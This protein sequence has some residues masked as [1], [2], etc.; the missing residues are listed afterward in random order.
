MANGIIQLT[1]KIVKDAAEAS[2][3]SFNNS[4]KGFQDRLNTVRIAG[5]GLQETFRILRAGI[6]NLLQL[7]AVQERAERK[8]EQAIRST[9]Q[10]AGF[11]ADELKKVA[12]SLQEVTVFGD[13]NILN[14]VTAQLLTFTN[15][16][17]DNFLRTQEAA[18]NLA[19]VL[20]GDLKSASIQ[21][22]KALN[23]P[24]ANLSALSRSGIQF[25]NE[26]EAVIKSLAETNRLAEAQTIILDELDKQYGGQAR[27]V[28]DLASGGMQQFFNV[29]GDVREELG[30]ILSEALLPFFK[31]LK[32]GLGIFQELP[33]FVK[34]VTAAVVILTTA[35]FAL[36]LSLGPVT[37]TLTALAAVG[38]GVSA[39]LS[40]ATRETNRLAEEVRKNS[41]VLKSYQEGLKGVGDEAAA[42]AAN[43]N[44]I[45]LAELDNSINA[46]QES[47]GQQLNLIE[48]T[49]NA[50]FNRL[51]K[52]L[53]AFQSAVRDSESSIKTITAEILPSP[54]S[55]GLFTPRTQELVQEQANLKFILERN[56]ANA[57]SVQRLIELG[58]QLKEN[59]GDSQKLN[60]IFKEIDKTI[61]II[62]Q[63]PF[64]S[65][66]EGVAALA[67][68]VGGLQ[69]LYSDLGD[70]QNRVAEKNKLIRVEEL[71][72]ELAT[73]EAQRIRLQLVSDEER[74]LEREF[75]IQKQSLEVKKQIAIET[76]KTED[77][78][79]LEQE[80]VLLRQQFQAETEV[81][82]VQR[83]RRIETVQRETT[84]E[85]DIQRL[86]IER[87]RA[88]LIENEVERL[89][90]EFRIQEQILERRLELARVTERTEEIIRLQSE[91]DITRERL[92]VEEE[93]A[94]VQQQRVNN[95]EIINLLESTT[96]RTRSIE[97][98][99]QSVLLQIEESRVLASAQ[100][101]E[102]RLNIRQEFAIRRLDIERSEL[103]AELDIQ[104]QRVESELAANQQIL[105]SRL[106]LARA[107]GDADQ[108]AA[109][110]AER[111]AQIEREAQIKQEF[112]D[113]QIAIDENYQ[114][115]RRA[116]ED[117]TN[118]QIIESR[119]RLEEQLIQGQDI[120][121]ASIEAG[122]DNLWATITST[123]QTG[124]EKVQAAFMAIV[125]TAIRGLGEWL[126]QDIIMSAR[127]V[128]VHQA[129]ESTKTAVTIQGVAARLGV[130]I[131]GI[132][133]EV[134]EVIKSIGIFLAQAAAKLVAFFASLGPIGLVAGLASIP[135]LIAGARAI[136]KNVGRFE[137]GA[138]LTQP[139]MG[140]FA[141]GGSPEAAIPLNERGAEFIAR[142]LPKIIVATPQAAS[143]DIPAL[144]EAL[145][146]RIE[147]IRIELR[148]EMD[149][150]Q[151]YRNTFPKYEKIEKGRRG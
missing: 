116:A 78:Q 39:Q 148:A 137:T 80:L 24:I 97:Q 96:Q 33:P 59:A 135:A 98:E 139:T 141:E 100:T 9:G 138:I 83:Q 52:Q 91:L 93:I 4:M 60:A 21:L 99:T 123:S 109:I 146:R 3:R 50:V 17:T 31:A 47:I 105:E 44:D 131:A 87:Q 46:T 140:L 103:V 45:S 122:Y 12:S 2:V 150:I 16:A 118:A 25:S 48:Q 143:N 37:L 42:L 126:K 10:A 86:S 41:T 40:A 127:S 129:G 7:S 27:A 113:R 13:E 73:L 28:A 79:K 85:Q 57:E 144:V 8:V 6:G 69:K 125:D 29:L 112:A 14:N 72:S 92:Q 110:E 151:F 95:Q 76:S 51:E 94:L 89:R 68:E 84:A 88:G 26:Q 22:G 5:Q 149:A 54:R 119:R 63:S 20:D 61:K 111:I 132:A 106:S 124:S 117:E 66:D 75:E 74:R 82:Q 77:V 107:G 142:L 32:D 145:G 36:G 81:L 55:V 38:L 114:A 71:N 70:I 35:I 130:V 65:Q 15:I 23:D 147:G 128:A 102:E 134:V 43:L 30:L 53:L 115:R 56:K 18:L 62:S 133:K 104:R 67:R 64:F 1:I 121:F 58:R 120:F 49:T 34:A 108:V 136:I 90:E 101:E 11:S 19:T